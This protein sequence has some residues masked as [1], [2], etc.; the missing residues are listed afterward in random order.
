MTLNFQGL[1]KLMLSKSANAIED[2]IHLIC[3]ADSNIY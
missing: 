2:N 1:E 3:F